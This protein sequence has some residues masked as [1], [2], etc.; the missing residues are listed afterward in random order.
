LELLLAGGVP[1]EQID[2]FPEHVDRLPLMIRT[3]RQTD[4][5][6]KSA[7]RPPR[8][9]CRFANPRVAKQ[10]DLAARSPL[11]HIDGTFYEENTNP[12]SH[13]EMGRVPCEAH[14]RLV[15]GS[16]FESSPHGKLG[17][18][19]AAL[20]K[21]I[22]PGHDCTLLKKWIANRKALL[23]ITSRKC[24]KLSISVEFRLW[25]VGPFVCQRIVGGTGS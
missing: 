23:R 12:A 25:S 6:L 10:N 20:E 19:R 14:S 24:R 3:D 5:R 17:D 9:Q 18:N 22:H 7:G 2:G 4:L 21:L 13:R 8:H 15:Q 16:H 1:Q 11:V